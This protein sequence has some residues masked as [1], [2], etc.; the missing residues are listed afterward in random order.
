M[1]QA[2]EHRIEH[3][4]RTARLLYRANL[5]YEMVEVVV[6]KMDLTLKSPLEALQRME[7]VT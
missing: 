6:K 4:C 3:H 2:V 1:S 7:R 5:N